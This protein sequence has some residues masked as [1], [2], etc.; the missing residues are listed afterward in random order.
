M[1]DDVCLRWVVD[2]CI[3]LARVSLDELLASAETGVATDTNTET[4]AETTP[5]STD[6]N[7]DAAGGSM[8][9]NAETT[10]SSTE[11]ADTDEVCWAVERV[12]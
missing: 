7:A 10:G 12:C 8:E 4:N 3:E 1:T 6:A 9:A 2:Y 5:S 11:A